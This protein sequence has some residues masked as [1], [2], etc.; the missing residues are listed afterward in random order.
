MANNSDAVQYA[1]N[2]LDDFVLTCCLLNKNFSVYN[3]H[4]LLHL[5]DDVNKFGHPDN[6]SAFPFENHI[7]KIKQSL[8]SNSNI[9]QQQV[10]RGIKFQTIGHNI[11]IE[12]SIP[13]FISNCKNKTISK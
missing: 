6:F 1:Q 12:K 2:L 10:I 3:V 9:L 13:Y 8:K 4:G 11:V 7:Q 5:L